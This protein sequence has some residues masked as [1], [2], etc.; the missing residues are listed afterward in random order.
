MTDT[1]IRDC[2][3]IFRNLL[4]GVPA[5]RV[6][7]AFRLSPAEVQR[8][9]DFVLRKIRSYAFEQRM[10]PVTVEHLAQARRPEH[11][12]VLLTILDRLNLAKA[13]A[14][15]HISYAPMEKVLDGIRGL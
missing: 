1:P 9:F 2:G 12:L 13:P 15:R 5:E 8:D 10:P 3:L 14:F 4:N 6:A 7:E 11:K